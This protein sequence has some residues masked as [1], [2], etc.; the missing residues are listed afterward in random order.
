MR[1]WCSSARL[2]FGILW[3]RSQFEAIIK[4]SSRKN[5]DL[6][7]LKK[8]VAVISESEIDVLEF[9]RSD[10]LLSGIYMLLDSSVFSLMFQFLLRPS[11]Y[12][13]LPYI[14]FNL[15]AYQNKTKK[16]TGIFNDNTA[17]LDNEF[18][19]VRLAFIPPVL[20]HPSKL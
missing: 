3:M 18:S 19:S 2:L 16:T 13:S 20:F 8:L 7:L 14:G 4:S 11:G 12:F 9:C 1:R 10:I 5:T 6:S 17:K 15:Y